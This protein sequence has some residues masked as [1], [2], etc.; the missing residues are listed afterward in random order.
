[1]N[2]VVFGLNGALCAVDALAVREVA[3]C[4]GIAPACHAPPDGHAVWS[5]ATYACDLRGESLP[6]IDLNRELGLGGTEVTP[7][8]R[9]LVAHIP[10]LGAGAAAALGAAAGAGVG[11]LVNRV[12][13]VYDL[14]D[15]CVKPAPPAVRAPGNEY[16]AGILASDG[17]TACV[18]ELGRVLRA[19]G[20]A[21]EGG[22]T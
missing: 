9:V 1:L 10:G 20:G 8:S 17:L 16:L 2:Y 21:G 13:N 14:P 12:D 4:E 18:I 6:V 19:G 11:F 7:D 5:Q 22:A 3:R 15:S